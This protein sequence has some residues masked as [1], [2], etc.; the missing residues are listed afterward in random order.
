MPDA[1]AGFVELALDEDAEVPARRT[2]APPG[3]TVQAVPGQLLAQGAAAATVR[4]RIA[5]LPGFSVS[6]E[7]A[8]AAGWRLIAFSAPE[9]LSAAGALEQVTETVNPLTAKPV[10]RVNRIVGC[11]RLMGGRAPDPPDPLNPPDWLPLGTGAGLG[12]R[13]AV[14]DT[15]PL[16]HP[17][18]AGHIAGLPEGAEV[19]G[20]AAGG[21]VA[22]GHCL[23]VAGLVLRYAPGAAVEMI[24]VLGHDGI[25]NDARLAQALADLDPGVQLV[26]LSL[27]TRSRRL[28][29]VRDV[30]ETLHSRGVGVVAAAGND[31]ESYEIRPAAERGVVGVASIVG[32]G[33]ALRLASWSQRGPWVRAAARGVGRYGPFVSGMRDT[34]GTS[35]KV[36]TRFGGWVRWSGASFAAPTVA[37]AAAAR[38]AAQPGLSGLEALEAVLADAPDVTLEEPEEGAPTRVRV[39]DPEPVWPLTDP[40]APPASA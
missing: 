15:P 39:V 22:R 30:L 25:G 13:V 11:P 14:L 27:G 6:D 33:E 20:T 16:Y 4:E 32:H 8:V 19:D 37:G 28:P 12:A 21:G 1:D 31:G 35:G 24:E 29:A 40:G 3:P 10:A 38:L 9:D 36:A 23:L 2:G 17:Q 34:Y 18:L 5:A 7:Q 26:N